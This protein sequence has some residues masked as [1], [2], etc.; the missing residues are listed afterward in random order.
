MNV[1]NLPC[2]NC[3]R[4]NEVCEY[5]PPIDENPPTTPPMP[6]D[7][8]SIN[9]G[10]WSLV[11]NFEAHQVN[12]FIAQ[13]HASPSYPLDLVS[14]STRSTGAYCAKTRAL[15]DFLLE[16]RGS[17]FSTPECTLWTAAIASSARKY[18][19]LQH[20]VQALAVMKQHNQRGL[21][22]PATDAYQHQL[23]AS[24]MFREATPTIN[25]E[26]WLSVKAF[27]IIMLVFQ[28]ASQNNCDEDHFDIIETLGALRSTMRIEAAARPY[29]RRTQFWQLIHA[30]T[31]NRPALETE[32]R[33]ACF[34]QSSEANFDD[35]PC[36]LTS[37]NTFSFA[38]Y[39]D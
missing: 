18:P 22:W 21:R 5:P 20:C 14:S 1:D 23:K 32:L 31:M 11:P 27:A 26:N 30:R 24:E 19:Y 34:L 16:N 39:L 33:Y 6:W 4:R 8:D 9:T 10:P 35:V 15:L 36:K 13:S 37:I 3:V 28:F 25:E 2:A 12:A 38:A 17:W 29:F 7:L